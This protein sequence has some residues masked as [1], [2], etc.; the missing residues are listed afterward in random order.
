[1]RSDGAGP[2]VKLSLPMK[3]PSPVSVGVIIKAMCGQGVAGAQS[4]TALPKYEP[5][6]G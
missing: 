5:T 6:A 4:C 1:M 2:S 3:T